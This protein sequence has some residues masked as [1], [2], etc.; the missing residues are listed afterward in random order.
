M[1]GLPWRGSGEASYL[2]HPPGTRC[3]GQPSKHCKP[4]PLGVISISP[5]ST[6]LRCSS[7][8]TRARS[9][10]GG[11]CSKDN[12]AFTGGTFYKSLILRYCRRHDLVHHH[13]PERATNNKKI[14]LAF[15]RTPELD[16]VTTV[17][18]LK[19]GPFRLPELS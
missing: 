3:R 18:N 10:S 2:R 16:T 7:T 9:S 13:R 17:S 19:I 14:A 5:S 1:G 4:L 8:R 12:D 15:R 11:G 6:A